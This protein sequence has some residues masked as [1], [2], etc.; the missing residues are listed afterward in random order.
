MTYLDYSRVLYLREVNGGTCGSYI[1]IDDGSWEHVA[2]P[3]STKGELRCGSL[4]YESFTQLYPNSR[5]VHLMLGIPPTEDKAQGTF[6][7][8]SGSY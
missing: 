3:R 6:K 4:S 5:E 1:K 7:V 8:Q 2:E